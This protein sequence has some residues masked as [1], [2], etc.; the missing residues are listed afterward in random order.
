MF[1]GCGRKPNNLHRKVPWPAWGCSV[2]RNWWKEWQSF[3]TKSLL[4]EESLPDQ[5]FLFTLHVF[6]WALR[7]QISSKGTTVE[8]TSI[9]LSSQHSDLCMFFHIPLLVSPCVGIFCKVSSCVSVL[10]SS[11][12]CFPYYLLLVPH[13]FPLLIFFSS[14]LYSLLDVAC[15][16]FTYWDDHWIT[17]FLFCFCNHLYFF[18]VIIL[19]QILV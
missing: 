16:R 12:S 4:L 11:K 9:W 8:G 3:I 13:L 6:K 15:L 17:S 19:S 18:V 14:Y 10:L 5:S 1:L 2:N 7:G